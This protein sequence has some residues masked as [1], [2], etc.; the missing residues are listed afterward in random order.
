MASKELY[1]DT[2]SLFYNSASFVFRAPMACKSF[3]EAIGHH[4]LEVGSLELSYQNDIYES[5]LLQSIFDPLKTSTKLFH[6]YLRIEARAKEPI[7]DYPMYMHQQTTYSDGDFWDVEFR[8]ISHP[9]ANLKA[10]R[11]LTIVGHPGTGEMEEVL[12]RASKNVERFA[13]S[14]G[15]RPYSVGVWARGLVPTYSIE[16]LPDEYFE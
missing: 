16:A 12:Y 14:Q 15:Q 5:S 1:Q 4:C 2:R 3:V 10:L 7:R 6:L 11:K 13:S 9:L 8:P